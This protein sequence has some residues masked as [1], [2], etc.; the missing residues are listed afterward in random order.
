MFIFSMNDDTCPWNLFFFIHKARLKPTQHPHPNHLPQ[1]SPTKI[2]PRSTPWHCD[3]YAHRGKALTLG[4][5]SLKSRRVKPVKFT[6][7]L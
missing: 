6:Q 7:N 4:V 5:I 3:C 2:T 1:A